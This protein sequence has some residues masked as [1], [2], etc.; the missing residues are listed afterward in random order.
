MRGRG[1]GGPENDAMPAPRS[2]HDTKPILDAVNDAVSALTEVVRS[3]RA[4]AKKNTRRARLTI[5]S[6]VSRAKAD[7]KAGARTA[8]ASMKKGARAVRQS[9]REAK[10]GIK[11]RLE[12]AWDVLT[13]EPASNGHAALP[14]RKRA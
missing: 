13:R 11:E 12:H 8:K 4:S 9:A 6:R 5:S 10:H 7:V 2:D 14:S 1:S 3:L